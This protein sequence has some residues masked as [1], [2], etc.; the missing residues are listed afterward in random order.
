MRNQINMSLAQAFPAQNNISFNPTPAGRNGTLIAVVLDE[1]GSMQSCRH[2][3][4]TGFNEFV[5]GQAAT[6][7]A[8]AAYLTLVKF[9]APKITTL[10]EN[11]NVNQV[12]PLTH[13]TYAP[14]G[15]TNLMDA[16]GETMTRI[17]QFLTKL[18]VEERPGVLIQIITDGE[19]N[20]SRTYSGDQ[21]KTMVKSAETD[22][23]WTFQ[24]LG[25]NV[26]AFKM[27][28]TFGMNAANT[29]S[30]STKNM[31]GTMDVILENT[32]TVRAAKMA[33]TST[34]EL[35]ASAAFYSDADRN[36]MTGE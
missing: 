6:S 1:S 17:N 21:I 34:Q 10:Y 14:N 22:G 5:Q 16:I 29:A 28:A 32:R 26:D 8:G 15:G 9:D 12:P 33:G 31:K 25:A 35:Y 24:F 20:S 27:G 18:S 23:D 36:K 11:M 30:Y 3:T 4:I 7:D 19:E 2:A 13:E